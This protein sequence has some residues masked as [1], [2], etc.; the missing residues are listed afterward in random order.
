MYLIVL[1]ITDTILLD[2][3]LSYR[4]IKV[5][6]DFDIR[7]ISDASCKL[8]TFGVY[9]LHQLTSWMIVLATVDRCLTFFYPWWA[10]DIFSHVCSAVLIGMTSLFIVIFNVHFLL[11]QELF[12]V[13]HKQTGESVMTCNTYLQRHRWFVHCIWPWIDLSVFA[14][15]PLAICIICNGCIIGQ[16]LY[17]IHKPS[18]IQETSA[19]EPQAG[20]STEEDRNHAKAL[21]SVPQRSSTMRP[22]QRP[23]HFLHTKAPTVTEPRAVPMKHQFLVPEP[24]SESSTAWRPQLVG[25]T[26]LVFFM[27]I[28]FIFTNLPLCIVLVGEVHW[29][30]GAS[31]DDKEQ[32]HIIWVIVHL[33]PNTFSAC[34]FTLYWCV[35]HRFRKTVCRMLRRHQVEPVDFEDRENH[36]EN[37]AMF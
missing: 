36:A 23:G 28:C 32:L 26:K 10:R 21:K 27:S 18:H 19:V 35:S 4:W 34:K 17:A 13:Y 9:L 8:Y 22:H 33:V 25:T 16:L 11:T 3:D 37:E 20:P 2:I 14:L 15:V 31:E 12:P 1:T 29:L 7:L 30:I 5:V 6:F 24:V